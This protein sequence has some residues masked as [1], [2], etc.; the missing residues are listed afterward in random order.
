MK[1][2]EDILNIGRQKDKGL[3][4]HNTR[5]SLG[6]SDRL[7]D[8]NKINKSKEFLSRKNKNKVQTQNIMTTGNKTDVNLALETKDYYTSNVGKNEISHMNVNRMPEIFEDPNVEYNRRLYGYANLTM[9]KINFLYNKCPIRT[10]II[11][12]IFN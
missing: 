2:D 11:K 12:C 3:F 9:E 10:F 4:A 8:V 7:F 6:S 1:N 5:K